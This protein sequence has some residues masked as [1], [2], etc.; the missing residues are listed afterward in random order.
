M[1]LQADVQK[2][3]T[4]NVRGNDNVMS[5]TST[6]LTEQDGQAVPPEAYE[7]HLAKLV[8]L[9]RQVAAAHRAEY[10]VEQNNAKAKETQLLEEIDRLKDALGILG[11]LQKHSSDLE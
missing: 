10:T 2:K 7:E 11:E 5:T 8:V 4:A 6:K 9:A 1:R 3:A